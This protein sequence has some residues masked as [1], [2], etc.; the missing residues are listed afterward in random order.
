MKDHPLVEEIRK[1]RQTIA[2]K[3]NYDAK[4]IAEMIRQAEKE[5]PERIA[6][7]ITVDKE[8]LAKC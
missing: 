4:K 8:A 2:R 5:H 3:C 6:S 1:T 7:E